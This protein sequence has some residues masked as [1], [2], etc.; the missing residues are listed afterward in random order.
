MPG[1]SGDARQAGGRRLKDLPIVCGAAKIATDLLRRRPI[2]QVELNDEQ[3]RIMRPV[4]GSDLSAPDFVSRVFAEISSTGPVGLE[5]ISRALGTAFPTPLQVD[6]PRIAAALDGLNRQTRNDLE[7]AARRVRDFYEATMPTLE[8]VGTD[9]CYQVMRPVATAGIYAPGGRAAYPSSLLM[10]AIPASVAG[11]GNIFVASPPGPDGKVNPIV[12]A[13]AAVAGVETV[14]ALGGA[15]AIAAMALGIAPV[16]RADVVSGPGNAFV[17]LALRQAVGLTGIATLPGPTETLIIADCS[18]DPGH[19][20]ADLLAQAEHDPMASPL[21]LLDC[22]DLALATAEKISRQL[23][24]LPRAEIAASALCNNG[25]IGVLDE[26]AEAVELANSFAP[27]HLCLVGPGA[28][29]L[30]DSINSAGGVFVGDQSPEVLGDYLAGPSHVMPV[31]GTARYA[32]PVSVYDFLKRTNYFALTQNQARR[33]APAAAR[34]AE[35]EGLSGH[36]RAARLR[37]R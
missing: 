14:Y 8:P 11:V 19:L 16:P 6:Q 24:T 34:L 1:P 17:V 15:Q 22:R 35:L 10:T 23:A 27:E 9:N 36:A 7:L 29:A 31:G 28:E 32:S 3:Q 21:L 12:L 25:G 20:A 26:L 5:R 37:L 30:A 18:A 33:L 2:T 13:A 4:F